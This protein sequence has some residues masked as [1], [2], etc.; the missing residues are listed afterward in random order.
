MSKTHPEIQE[1][2]MPTKDTEYTVTIPKDVKSYT[3][4]TRGNHE[5]KL[6]YKTEQV[7]SATGEFITIPAGSAESEDDLNR[8][9]NF[10][11]YV[12]CEVDGEKLEVK[13]WK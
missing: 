4:K 7:A 8:V 11:L 3:V 9:D 5:F 10:T 12:S 13:I 6:A 1:I 2:D